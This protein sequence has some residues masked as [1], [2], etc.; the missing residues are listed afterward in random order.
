MEPMLL[1]ANGHLLEEALEQY[2]F[3]RLSEV[4]T[5]TVEEHILVCGICQSALLETDEYILLMKAATADYQFNRATEFSRADPPAW[6][7][8]RSFLIRRRPL[9][10]MV[11]ATGVAAVFAIAF[12]SWRG[13][14]VSGTS[15]V[16]LVALRG[17]EGAVMTQAAAGKSLDLLID[18]TDLPAA[19]AYRLEMVS[20]TGSRSWEG[21]L[22]KLNGKLSA[23]VAKRLK[24]GVYW[25]RL[26][27]G[28]ELV[29]EFGLRLD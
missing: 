19:N 10:A 5:E 28:E 8:L 15:A 22:E 24:A 29:R 6:A 13:E 11:W 20:G 4:D 18:L 16:Q 27:A 2:A 26:Y 1:A 21:R 25:V 9:T 14:P 7:R 3:N 23:H 17:G 12:T